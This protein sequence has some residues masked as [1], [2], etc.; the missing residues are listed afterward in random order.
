MPFRLWLLRTAHERIVD[1][2]RQHLH[3]QKRAV[4]R[5]LALPDGSSLAIAQQLLALDSGPAQRAIRNEVAGQVRRC[6]AQLAES[7]REILMLRC[8]EGLNNPDAA[9]VLGLKPETSKKR[10]ARALLRMRQVLNS[11]GVNNSGLP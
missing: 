6:L 3:A 7:D 4:D 2:E 11:A 8:F 9:A 5:E 1:V 10:F